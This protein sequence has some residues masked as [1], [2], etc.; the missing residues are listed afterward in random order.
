[1]KR[2]DNSEYSI[3]VKGMAA[4][5]HRFSFDI[6]GEFFREYENSEVIEAGLSAELDVVK[7]STL[8]NIDGVITGNVGVECDRCLEEVFL[9]IEA[10]FNLIV[11]FAKDIDEEGDEIMVIDP[12]EGELYLSQLF[13]DTVIL[14]LPIQRVHDEGYCDPEMVKK[15]E[16]LKGD[17]GEKV[18]ESK[19][20]FSVLKNL[21]N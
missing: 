4:G 2:A 12:S 16:S 21:K 20:P 5:K 10:E 9:P 6:G 19:S 17:S 8:M 1:M 11:K 14:S 15:L 7:S 18:E 13:Y 3:P